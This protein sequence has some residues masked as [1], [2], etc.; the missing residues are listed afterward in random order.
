MTESH[1]DDFVRSNAIEDQIRIRCQHDAP[2]AFATGQLA[3][4]RVPCQ[5]INCRLNTITYADGPS[6]GALGNIVERLLDLAKRRGCVP[7][8]QARYFAKTART[9]ASSANW[10]WA[11]SASAAARSA[12]SS[13]LSG[14]I[15]VARQL[16]QHAGEGILRLMRQGPDTINCLFEKLCHRV[17]MLTKWPCRKDMAAKP[18][19]I[20]LATQSQLSLHH[21]FV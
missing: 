21:A 15:I 7:Q 20:C 6:R 8:L 3:G 2:N 11:I 17:N 12:S 10:P 1:D 9:C 16:H 5:K 14:Y 18:S 13:A 19:T 4:K